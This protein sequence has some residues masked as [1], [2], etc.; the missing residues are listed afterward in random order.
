MN[1]NIYEFESYKD[2]VRERVRRT[3]ARGKGEFQKISKALGVHPS[4]VSQIFKGERELS[5]EQAWSLSRYLGLNPEETEYLLTLVQL[6]RA[7]KPEFTAFLRKRRESLR[8]SVSIPPST[9]KTD[10]IRLNEHDQLVFYSSWFYSAIRL[11]SALPKFQTADAIVEELGLPIGVVRQTLAFL[12]SKGLCVEERG[13]VRPGPLRTWIEAESP[14]AIRHHL[15]WRIKAM[16][17]MP[18]R[19]SSEFFATFPVAI[20]HEDAVVVR[21][22][23]LDTFDEI[24]GIVRSS[25]GAKVSCLNIDWFDI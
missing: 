20:G 17:R 8:Q 14:L 18:R 7:D 22:L 23:L 13:K 21:S 1:T 2:Y 5:A 25:K 9:T 6:A 12:V 10:E 3:P 24:D 15:N 19:T 16:D 4:L 11:I